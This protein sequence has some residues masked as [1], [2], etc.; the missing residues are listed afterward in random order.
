MQILV[1][2]NNY[3]ISINGQHFA[4]FVHRQP[5]KQIRCL[6]VK[7]DVMDV[8]VEQVNVLE[9]PDTLPHTEPKVIAIRPQWTE[10]PDTGDKETLPFYGT[11][12][13]QT[14]TDSHCLHILGRVKI[15]PHS[16]IINLQRGTKIWPHPTI[17]FHLNPRFAGI[18]GQHA[19]VRNSWFDG[20]WDREERSDICVDF[21]PGKN[22][23]LSILC[24]DG[25]Y[26]VYLNKK[27]I[28]EYRHRQDPGI[29]DTVYVQGDIHLKMVVLETA[30]KM[31]TIYS[32]PTYMS[33]E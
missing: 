23:H 6:Q 9:Y 32:N 18:G 12:S 11:L 8:Q 26:H 13:Q 14:L 10:F 25:A 20:K 30:P 7:G 3:L 1:T 15:L 16:F 22:F 27:F 5:F 17:A 33:D 24:S 4:S 2:D 21:M 29:V 19:I 28:S 31:D